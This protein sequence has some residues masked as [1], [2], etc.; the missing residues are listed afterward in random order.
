MP[1]C[2]HGMGQPW[3]YVHTGEGDQPHRKS[4]SRS[5]LHKVGSDLGYCVWFWPLQYKKAIELLEG[6]KEGKKGAEGP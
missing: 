5:A 2:A 6:S 3:T 4:L 1:D